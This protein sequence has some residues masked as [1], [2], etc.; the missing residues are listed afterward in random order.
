MAR[1]APFV[2]L[3]GLWID[4]RLGEDLGMPPIDIGVERATEEV[5]VDLLSSL[6]DSEDEEVESDNEAETP[7]RTSGPTATELL[8]EGERGLKEDR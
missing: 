7:S 5:V 1:D 3:G 6:N 8:A 4:M 2:G